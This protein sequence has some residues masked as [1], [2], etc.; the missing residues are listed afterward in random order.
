[1]LKKYDNI[2]VSQRIKNAAASQEVE[3]T[4]AL[5]SYWHG[6]A[7]STAEWSN[8]WS[9]SDACS[10]A[11]QFGRMR[12]FDQ[13][14]YGSVSRYDAMAFE[15]Y[16]DMYDIYP[17]IGGKDP[18]PLME[19]SVHTLVNEVIEVAADGMSA[20]SSFITPGVIHS[21]LTPGQ[22]R[23]CNFLWERYGSDFVCEDGEWKYLHEHV[24]PDVIGQIDC[25]NW[26]Y[27][28][29]EKLAENPTFVDKATL[30]E[31]PPVSDPG[32]LHNP[33]LPIS[34]PQDTVPWPLPYVTLDED[35]TYTKADEI[36][37][38]RKMHSSAERTISRINDK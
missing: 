32:P 34:T 1:M 12:G 18:R 25:T 14:W 11:H 7:D 13:V 9:R 17:E 33:Y 10:W 38:E 36:R 27:S 31:I 19:C 8:I 15:N 23:Y 6:R 37:N 4:K 28:T 3:V 5:H 26:A 30:G 20:R 16:L 29:Y 35:N 24:C 2:S 22:A 21:V